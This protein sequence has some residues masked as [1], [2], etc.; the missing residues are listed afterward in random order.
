[1]LDN[2]TAL[3]YSMSQN[4]G[5][6]ALLLG[7]G[8]S[9][10]SG[11]P[12][13][14]EI[15][16]DLIRKVAA[17]DGSDAGADPVD[18]LKKSK[19]LDP[20]YSTLL[21]QLAKT[22]SERRAV[23]A[24][25]IE[26]SDEDRAEGRKLPTAAHRAIAQMVR[27][28][29]VRVIV[30]TN[31][32]RL[33]EIALRDVGIEPTVITTDDAAKGAEPIT[34]A[35]CTIIKVHGDYLDTRIKNTEQEL[36]TYTPELNALLDRVFDEFGLIVS[37]WSATW[38][39][40]LRDSITRNVSRRYS[41]YWACRGEPTREAGELI[42]QRRGEV[43]PCPSADAFFMDLN[44]KLKTLEEL[45]KPHPL[46]AAMAV[47]M[48]KRY[49]VDDASRIKL[50]DL[51]EDAVEDAIKR[52]PADALSPSGQTTADEFVRRIEAYESALSTLLPVIATGARWSMQDPE[53]WLVTLE[54]LLT[55]EQ[56]GGGLTAFLNLR[57]YP[58][59]MAFYAVG[60]GAVVGR[61][62]D[63][64][65]TLLYQPV[66]KGRELTHLT[67]IMNTFSVASKEVQQ[68]LPGMENRKTPFSDHFLEHLSKALPRD[69]TV[70]DFESAFDTFELLVALSYADRTMG[71]DPETKSYWSPIGRFVWQ[72][73][74]A[75]KKVREN[76]VQQGPEWP[77]YLAGLFSGDQARGEALMGG[78]AEATRRYRF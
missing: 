41:H 22:P 14:W 1:M 60:V 77:W 56:D 20:D 48:V 54:R 16:L 72:H 17:L 45:S 3:A 59:L 67:D 58:A 57:R 38:D 21:D 33:L 8:V 13:G 35:R 53:Q 42:A 28:G 18:W 50:N 73:D 52:I 27:S 25:Y 55:L 30:T 36:I 78:L 71:P 11:I 64:L 63:L 65:K 23:L 15:T 24:G 32:D 34:H 37:G 7:S 6:Y 44:E 9:R 2:T 12:T 69:V 29:Y 43:V 31:F 49:V 70:G 39:P 26:A 19:G 66:T 10:D 68:M 47:A 61:R 5:V 46:S 4:R 51:V 62:Y 75:L 40:A 74:G 76:I